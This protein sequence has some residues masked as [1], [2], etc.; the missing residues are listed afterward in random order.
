MELLVRGRLGRVGQCGI[1]KDR[2]G[3]G[4]MGKAGRSKSG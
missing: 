4:G 2:A 3:E 1:G